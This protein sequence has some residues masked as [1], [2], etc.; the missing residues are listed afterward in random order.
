MKKPA[1]PKQI[2]VAAVILAVVLGAIGLYT[3]RGPG[4][5]ADDAP[6]EKTDAEAVQYMQQNPPQEHT[7]TGGAR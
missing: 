3:F 6:G 7:N 2:M 5:D 4:V 1:S